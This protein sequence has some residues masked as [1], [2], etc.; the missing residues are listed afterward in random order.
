M[1]SREHIKPRISRQITPRNI[2]AIKP[3]RQLAWN[4]QHDE[5]DDDLWY[6]TVYGD[7]KKQGNGTSSST[8]RSRQNYNNDNIEDDDYDSEEEEN[9]NIPRSSKICKLLSI[10]KAIYKCFI[11]I[12][13]KQKP[14]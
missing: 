12:C 9:D 2:R 3:K 4:K 5:V 1:P 6:T 10:F 11:C 8:T 7:S 14:N 13:K